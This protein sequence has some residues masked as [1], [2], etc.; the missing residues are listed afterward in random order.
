MFLVEHKLHSDEEA[1]TIRPYSIV[2][3]SEGIK[4][5]LL[6]KHGVNYQL[7]AINSSV[8]VVKWRTSA[9]QIIRPQ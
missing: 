1:L 5:K 4:L 2:F 9:T 6:V 7:G 8:N 3:I